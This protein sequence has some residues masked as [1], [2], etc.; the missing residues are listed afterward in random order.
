M[1]FDGRITELHSRRAYTRALTAALGGSAGAAFDLP[2]CMFVGGSSAKLGSTMD[3]VDVHNKYQIHLN[4][5]EVFEL[6]NTAGTHGHSDAALHCY[7]LSLQ[8]GPWV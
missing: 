7:S 1:A 3:D 2:N 4:K 5:A 8:R 6:R